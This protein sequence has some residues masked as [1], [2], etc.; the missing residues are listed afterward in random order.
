MRKEVDWVIEEVEKLG[1]NIRAYPAQFSPIDQ[2]YSDYLASLSIIIDQSKL[3]T[4]LNEVKSSNLLDRN[5]NFSLNQTNIKKMMEILKTKLEDKEIRQVEYRQLIN[6]HCGI[7]S[8]AQD[9]IFAANYA[10]QQ[11]NIG[12]V[13]SYSPGL[14]ERNIEAV[15]IVAFFLS[16]GVMPLIGNQNFDTAC[17][18]EGMANLKDI[19]QKLNI[20]GKIY[21]LVIS[22]KSDRS[23]KKYL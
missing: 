22:W 2:A 1:G 10:M 5:G 7:F 14:G 18:G 4:I 20:D 8:N 13:S 15:W 12:I 3:I 16:R 17:N 21:N 6:A 23:E 11:N 9:S 19:G